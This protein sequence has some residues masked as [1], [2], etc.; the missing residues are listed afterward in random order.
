MVK[1]RAALRKVHLKVNE[2][3]SNFSIHA[4]THL[5][6]SVWTWRMECRRRRCTLRIAR[7]HARV[8][9]RLCQRRKSSEDGGTPTQVSKPLVIHLCLYCT[10]A[11]L[12][13]HGTSMMGG[14]LCVRNWWMLLSGA[15]W[16]EA[17]SRLQLE[18]LTSLKERR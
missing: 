8:T 9:R 7:G 2:T 11:C 15:K 16:K 3:W 10:D 4:F 6:A 13:P 1:P 5:E 18:I 14:S 17:F 12:P